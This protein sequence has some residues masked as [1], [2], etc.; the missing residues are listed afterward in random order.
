ML[1]AVEERLDDEVIGGQLELE[2]WDLVDQNRRCQ[3]LVGIQ[4]NLSL[5]QNIFIQEFVDFGHQLENLR[6]VDLRL[7]EQAELLDVFIEIVA[8]SQQGF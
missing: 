4:P 7:R 8:L 5:R 3:S 6:E 2:K 1:Q